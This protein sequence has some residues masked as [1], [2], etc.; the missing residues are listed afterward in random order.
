MR[1]LQIG[2]WKVRKKE[3]GCLYHLMAG[4]NVTAHLG[5]AD[6][7]SYTSA[8]EIFCGLKPKQNK[9]QTLGNPVSKGFQNFIV[10]AKYFQ[11]LLPSTHFPQHLGLGLLVIFLCWWHEMLAEPMFMLL[12]RIFLKPTSLVILKLVNLFIF[13]GWKHLMLNNLDRIYI[14]FD[15]EYN[16]ISVSSLCDKL[17]AIMHTSV[18]SH[19]EEWD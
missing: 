6:L 3:E 16:W 12:R 4:T 2:N 10:W 15:N 17:G 14:D 5:A 7:V 8:N 1:I 18:A 13:K 9:M 19:W 11:L